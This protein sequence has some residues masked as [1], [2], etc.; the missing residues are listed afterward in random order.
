MEFHEHLTE[1]LVGLVAEILQ[2]E[3]SMKKD[4][5]PPSMKSLVKSD[6]VNLRKEVC[7]L[8]HTA[9]KSGARPEHVSTIL[10]GIYKGGRR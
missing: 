2:I 6:L 4:D 10:K 7:L 1:R 5:F 3:A 8:A 9:R